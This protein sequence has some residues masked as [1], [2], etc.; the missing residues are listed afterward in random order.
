MSFRPIYEGWDLSGRL[1]R[2][3]RRSFAG[4]GL[5]RDLDAART[6]AASIEDKLDAHGLLD[7][8]GG[9]A[10]ANHIV[11]AA[12]AAFDVADAETPFGQH[13]ASV[14]ADLIVYEGWFALPSL[15]PLP[16]LTRAELWE[17]EDH[18][19]RVETIVD[20]LD[21]AAA[22]AA[23]MLMAL[24]APLV[25]QHPQLLS[26]QREADHAFPADLRHLIQDAP[27]L[28]EHWLQIPFAPDFEPL[29]LTPR[30]RRR[31]EFNLHLASGGVPGDLDSV[32]SPK[33]PTRQSAIP[34]KEIAAHYLD[35]TPL[36]DLLSYR[37][38]IALPQATRFEH[39]HIVAGSGHG[40][41][42]TLQHLILHDL[43]M[44]AHGE[45]SIIVIDSQSDL[46]NTIAGLAVFA[47]GGALDGRLVLIDPTDIEWP[48]AL[49]LFDAGLERLNQYSPLDR[50]RLTNSILELYD[51]VLGSLLDAGMTQKQNV[52]FRY[53]TR[54]LLHIPGA[55]IHTLRELLEDGG[56]DRYRGYID[57]LQGS[58]RAF[59]EQEFNGKEFTAT[60]RQ[61]LRRLY[62]ILENQTF[63]RM[64][65][66]PKSRLDLFAEMNA[67]K[68]ILINTAKD[69][70]KENGTEIFGRFF[71][72]M[73]TQAAQERAT[74]APSDR[75]PTFVYVDEANDYFDRNI[76]II[77]SQARK[78]NVG[79]I[80]AHQYL[81][82]LESKLHE[83][84]AA[85]T[86]IKFAGGV[87]AKDARALAG[88]LRTEAAFIE[89]QPRLSFAA[90]IKGDHE[91]AVSLSIKP[92][93]MEA[94]QGMTADE[95]DAVLTQMRQRY[96][97]HYTELFPEDAEKSEPEAEADD[98]VE[99]LP[100]ESDD[101]G[102]PMKW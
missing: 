16:E 80:L 39:M 70:L 61:V 50:E 30:L 7:S 36:L 95:R 75:L 21:T 15:E 98:P 35:G 101:T 83:A 8:E 37:L 51:F 20:N 88:D 62:G 57:K 65:S 44:V 102:E 41:T 79:M 19:K 47:P 29:Q 27:A 10:F 28:V 17:L 60:K 32:R 9:L 94:L 59:F 49:N 81:G 84:I 64:F 82:Q 18:L 100:S 92:G 86:S 1:S 34:A 24:I 97:I 71:I 13:L 12:M 40:K 38:D 87:S 31:L 63:E 67:G 48:V 43:D 69:L 77:L 68:V 99:L 22:V 66:H 78:Y 45:G 72:A 90:F 73:I 91:C 85:N 33:L 53:I 52:I 5:N 58:A 46:I 96:A 42:Q 11:A 93:R 56:Y 6:L 2:K 14:M 26:E 23:D 25:E 55:T 76:G 89:S 3:V 74:L 4:I 54:L